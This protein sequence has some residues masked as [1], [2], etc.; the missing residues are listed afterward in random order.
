MGYVARSM[1]AP[2]PVSTIG[3]RRARDFWLSIGIN[4]HFDYGGD[5]NANPF[6]GDAHQFYRN[7]YGYDNAALPGL[8][9]PQPGYAQLILDLGIKRLRYGGKPWMDPYAFGLFQAW[10]LSDSAFA[11]DG[12]YIKGSI[13]MGNPNVNGEPVAVMQVINAIYCR[14]T[15]GDV[16]SAFVPRIAYM[17]CANEPDLFGML[18]TTRQQAI[19]LYNARTSYPALAN[20]PLVG[21][22]LVNDG[23]FSTVGDLSPYIEVRNGH[24]YQ[25]AWEPSRNHYWIQSRTNFYG[26]RVARYVATETG[27][28]TAVG[29][30]GGRQWGVPEDVQA[31][32]IVLTFLESFRQGTECTFTYELLDQYNDDPTG[33]GANADENNFGIIRYGAINAINRPTFTP[34]PAYT[35]LQRLISQVKDYNSS[36]SSSN[37]ILNVVPTQ[38]D[39]RSLLLAKSNGKRL[40]Y[41]WRDA[42]LWNR[43][44]KTAV[45][46]SSVNQVV[47]FGVVPASVRTN[48]PSVDGTYSTVTP[49]QTMTFSVDQRP[50]CVEITPLLL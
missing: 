14:A 32:Y 43:D 42:S 39:V 3:Q 15:P 33:T 31:H 48:R 26:S 28:H 41:L 7:G 9:N 13:G 36:Y 30:S 35:A 10:E 23:S 37:F 45:A 29:Y 19:D 50:L 22:S 25:G 40:L 34:K 18:A 24:P 47:N 16:N 44:T 46:L 2:T 17:E 6:T 49:S 8:P 11:L 27:Y 5:P 20:I 38:N 4:V 21:P 1:G 12:E